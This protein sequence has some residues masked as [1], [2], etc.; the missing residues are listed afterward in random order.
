M[1]YNKYIPT[2]LFLLSISLCFFPVQGAD[3]DM[4]SLYGFDYNSA[5]SSPPVNDHQS[6]PQEP[7]NTQDLSPTVPKPT[8]ENPWNL[9]YK[10]MFE[11][12]DN[13]EKIR[14]LLTNNKFNWFLSPLP[15]QY[16]EKVSKLIGDFQLRYSTPSNTARF[17]ELTS[18]CLYSGNPTDG[19]LFPSC[20][21]LAASKKKFE[22]F[23]TLYPKLVN[24]EILKLK[25][26]VE[27]EALNVLQI[28]TLMG[29]KGRVAYLMN[30]REA[31]DFN[32]IVSNQN[33]IYR[34]LNLSA[35]AAYGGHF[36]LAIWLF[37]EEQK[38]L[39]NEEIEKAK[40][41]MNIVAKKKFKY[42]EYT[43]DAFDL[44][45]IAILENKQG[46]AATLLHKVKRSD[47]I[48]RKNKSV[49][50]YQGHTIFHIT[51]QNKGPRAIINLLMALYNDEKD[52]LLLEEVE[53]NQQYGGSN[54]AQLALSTDNSYVLYKLL[55]YNRTLAISSILKDRIFEDGKCINSLEIIQSKKEYLQDTNIIKILKKNYRL[56]V[57]G[58]C[59][60]WPKQPNNITDI[61]MIIIKYYYL[62]DTVK[63]EEDN[64]IL[65]KDPSSRVLIIFSN[66]L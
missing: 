11:R 57:K 44:S 5:P 10:P 15:F 24:K 55:N 13:I 45:I 52:S 58:I 2:F 53:D 34:N 31:D 3:S 56:L 65:V 32:T 38:I 7:Q 60:E 61:Q 42:S 4:D 35:L 36:G 19:F 22:L 64:E 39:N 25:I 59:R 41:A 62:G 37:S 8:L 51:I 50:K 9:L 20:V 14:Q 28:L 29:K 18:P 33:M 23:F 43:D 46:L 26:S 40:A 66:T 54:A 63:R 21:A 27:V 30:A 12:E 16:S 17:D 48:A 47:V 6:A 1:S 49:Q